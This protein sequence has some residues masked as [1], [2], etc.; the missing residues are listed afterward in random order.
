MATKED[1]NRALAIRLITTMKDHGGVDES[2]IADGAQ[3]VYPD[4]SVAP[5]AK[6]K[7]YVKTMRKLMPELP[8]MTV[9]STIAEGD[10]VSLEVAGKCTLADGRQYNNHYHFVVVIRDGLVCELREYGNTK[11]S[12]ELFASPH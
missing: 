2:L 8:T 3:W 7:E 1:M 5:L 12:A 4:Q 6:L 10:R 9:T 11:L